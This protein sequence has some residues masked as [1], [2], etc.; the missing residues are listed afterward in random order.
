[1]RFCGCKNAF[2][3]YLL[4]NA[5][6][7]QIFACHCEERSDVAIRISLRQGITESS[8]SGEYGKVLRIRPKYYLLAKFLCGDADCHTSV[9]TGSQ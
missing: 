8:T 2:R 6:T 5:N 7:K 3:Q 1:M 9:R 4:A